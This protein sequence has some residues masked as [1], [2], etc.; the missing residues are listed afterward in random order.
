MQR[1]LVYNFSG[2]L[3]DISHLFPNERLARIAAIVSASGQPVDLLDRANFFDL[4]RVGAAYLE[5]LGQLAFHDTDAVYEAQLYAEAD[6]LLAR[7]Y[8]VIFFNLWHGTGF[9]FTFDLACRLKQMN[10]ALRMYGVGQ[11]VDW[12]KEHIL[13][14]PN[15]PLD[16]LITGL[17]Y[18]AIAAIVAGDE[19]THCPNTIMMQ[20]GQ[21][22]INEKLAINVDEYPIGN[23][24]A[25]IYQHLADK[26]PMH[27]ITLSNQAC[28]NHC[29]FCVRTENYGKTN[30]PRNIDAVLDEMRESFHRHHIRYFRFEDSTPPRDALTAISRAIIASEM[31]GQ[32][33]FTAFSRIDTNSTEDFSLLRQAGCVALFFGVESLDDENLLRLRKGITYE[34][35]RATMGRAHDAGI[36]SIGSFI[37][38]MPGDT[39]ESIERTVTR[40][41]ENREIFDSVLSLPAGVYPPTEWGKDPERYGIQLDEDY[42]ERFLTFPI[43]Y[44]LPLKYWPS[45]PFRYTLFGKPASEVA[46]PEIVAAFEEFQQRIKTETGIPCIPDYYFLMAHYLHQDSASVTRQMV[47]C[48]MQRDYAGLAALFQHQETELQRA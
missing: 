13:T 38:P 17:G 24:D 25:T 9:K 47:T 45:A 32:I 5:H 15:N 16:G 41:R 22:I 48:L 19:V 42:L 40:I 31:N 44:L 26:L 36:V 2:E 18:N 23:Y 10:P 8:D 11:K 4:Q 29:V 37:V 6:A 43:K 34:S 46:F 12:F 21:L 28:P 3:D 20:D 27:T 33:H 7:R 1:Y 30:I 14:L 39:H 35:V